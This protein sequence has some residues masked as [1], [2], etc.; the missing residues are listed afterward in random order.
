M[1]VEAKEPELSD[2]DQAALYFHKYPVPG[3]LEI[4]A[5]KPLGNQRQEFTVLDPSPAHLLDRFDLT[6]G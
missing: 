3:K 4:Q 6:L 2:L 1:N 5:T